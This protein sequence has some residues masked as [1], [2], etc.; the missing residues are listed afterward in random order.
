MYILCRA[1][2]KNLHINTSFRSVG[3]N[4]GIYAMHVAKELHYKGS[5]SFFFQVFF[6]ILEAK[7]NIFLYQY[8]CV[9]MNF[10]RVGK[11]A[12]KNEE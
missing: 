5:F 11:H 10:M 1:K 9:D 12:M 7:G 3:V 6:I 4:G 8:S 2:R